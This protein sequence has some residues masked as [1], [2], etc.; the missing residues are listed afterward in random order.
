M[1]KNAKLAEALC[2]KLVVKFWSPYESGSTEGYVLDIGPRFFLLAFIND[3]MRFNGFQC[4][5]FSDVRGLQAPH[6]YADFV[7]AALRR[8]GQTIRRKPNVDLSNLSALLNSASRLFPLVTVHRERVDAETC[9]IGRVAGVTKSR[10][11]LLE[12]GPDALWEEKPSELR[13]NEIT[14][15][16]FGGGYEEA[17]HLVGGRPKSLKISLKQ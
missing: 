9:K 1:K 11:S 2:N 15:V 5:R 4:M 3:E 14:R 16:D 17:L 13:L 10:L 6:Q 7:V 12:I 8:R